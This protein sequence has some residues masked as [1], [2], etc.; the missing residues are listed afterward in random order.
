MRLDSNG[1]VG[2]GT[3]SPIHLFQAV[4]S[5]TSSEAVAAFGNASIANGLQIQTNG[6]LDWG[7]NALNN[8]NL[9]FSTNQ[10]E[11]LR[12]DSSGRLLVGTSSQ[13]TGTT[14]ERPSQYSKFVLTGNSSFSTGP[15]YAALGIGSSGTA[16]VADDGVGTLNFTD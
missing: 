5:G 11:R 6:N 4:S 1:N 3:G 13:L 9:T 14:G 12:I 16:L 15:A 8:R 2:I 10:Q 7:F